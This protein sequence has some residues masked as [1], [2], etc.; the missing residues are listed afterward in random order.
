MRPRKWH[1]FTLW[2]IESVTIALSNQVS[3]FPFRV[4]RSSHLRQ[5][6]QGWPV[7]PCVVPRWQDPLTGQRHGRAPGWVRWSS[8]QP[9]PGGQLYEQRRQ[10]RGQRIGRRQDLLLGL[11]RGEIYRANPLSFPMTVLTSLYFNSAD[12]EPIWT[13]YSCSWV[14]FEHTICLWDVLTNFS[15]EIA[16]DEWQSWI[17]WDDCS[18][19]G[20]LRQGHVVYLSAVLQ[21]VQILRCS[22]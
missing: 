22:P 3:P 19:Y 17:L 4:N 21:T 5:L 1:M 7:H 14:G 2:D 18:R 10:P 11:G 6:H 9:V 8:Q 12:W 20:K 13:L 15:A 16:G